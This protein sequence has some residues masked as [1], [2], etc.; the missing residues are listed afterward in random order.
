MRVGDYEIPV[1]VVD[2]WPDDEIGIYDS[3]SGDRLGAIV[4]IGNSEEEKC[5][6]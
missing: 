5:V 1:V 3:I 6:S 2:G 4:N